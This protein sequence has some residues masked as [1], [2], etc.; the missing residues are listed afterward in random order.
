MPSTYIISA[1][2]RG[3][4]RLRTAPTNLRRGLGASHRVA[5]CSSCRP[6]RLH[7][8][9]NPPPNYATRRRSQ[10]GIGGR[11]RGNSQYARQLRAACTAVVHT[12]PFGRMSVTNE[13][14]A[15]P[16]AVMRE[17]HPVGCSPGNGMLQGAGI[18]ASRIVAEF[19]AARKPRV[20]IASPQPSTKGRRSSAMRK[21]VAGRGG[22]TAGPTR[23]KDAIID[24]DSA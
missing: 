22:P 23:V 13:L 3:P 16:P 9:T 21:C 11:A 8:I 18:L 10:G 15:V 17:V 24:F 12:T 19:T 2:V 6:R 7:R 1:A 4:K 5:I 14:A 20:M